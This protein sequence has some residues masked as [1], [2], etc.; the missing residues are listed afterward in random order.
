MDRSTQWVEPALPTAYLGGFLS[1]LR[2][3]SSGR[4]ALEHRGDK[5]VLSHSLNLLLQTLEEIPKPKKEFRGLKLS[6]QILLP[7][8]SPGP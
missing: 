1:S 6:P 2:R 5:S 3:W 7:G 8:N 4:E